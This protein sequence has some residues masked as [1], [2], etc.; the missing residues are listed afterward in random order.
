MIN[1]TVE[2]PNLKI[3]GLDN[4]QIRIEDSRNSNL[5]IY[6]DRCA[7]LID[8]VKLI[9]KAGLVKYLETPLLK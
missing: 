1:L 2:I 6:F 3:P 5:G 7:D 4:M 9:S 8:K